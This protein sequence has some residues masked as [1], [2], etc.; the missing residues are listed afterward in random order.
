MGTVT[1]AAVVVSVDV[2]A[3]DTTAPVAVAVAAVCG[4]SWT[5]DVW[6]YWLAVV[7]ASGASAA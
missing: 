1:V 7:V 3:A 2:F 4:V 6:T 5:Y